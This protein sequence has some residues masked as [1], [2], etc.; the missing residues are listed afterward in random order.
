MQKKLGVHVNRLPQSLQLTFDHSERAHGRRARIGMTTY[1]SIMIITCVHAC[2]V[3]GAVASETPCGPCHAALQ[4][5]HVA[6]GAH[7]RL[8]LR[9]ARMIYDT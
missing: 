7:Q 8:Q 2:V 4:G 6:A 1:R 9:C 5:Y 3:H